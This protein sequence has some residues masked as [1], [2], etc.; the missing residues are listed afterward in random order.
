MNVVLFDRASADMLSVWLTCVCVCVL[1]HGR[2]TLKS[3]KR[4]AERT[5]ASTTNY[6]VLCDKYKH[7]WCLWYSCKLHRS[8]TAFIW[9]RPYRTISKS[10]NLSTK[11]I[12]VFIH[13]RHHHDIVYN[14]EERKWWRAVV[15]ICCDV[16]APTIANSMVSKDYVEL[17]FWTSKTGG[18]WKSK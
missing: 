6:Y 4:S 8:A 12:Y 18:E 5:S 17:A 13:R 15:C 11:C 9:A 2:L 1:G 3:F 16:W 7:L 10:T 14:F